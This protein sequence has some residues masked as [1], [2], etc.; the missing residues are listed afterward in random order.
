M[1]APPRITL[2]A[3]EDRT[4]REL[5]EARSVPQRT[6]D[7]AHRLRLNALGWNVPKIAKVFDFHQHTV[8][9]TLRRWEP[10]G[11]G[12]LWQA[13]GRGA[14]PRWKEEDLSG[15]RIQKMLKK[16]GYRWKR[17][18]KSQKRKQDPLGIAIKQADLQMLVRQAEEGVIELKYL[19]EA[20]FC[21]ESPP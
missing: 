15:D 18:R 14:K 2:T 11:L 1:P 4:L 10:R 8:R 5:R 17:T 16:K 20:G 3:E 6:R 9:A 19:D 21:L 7:R 13:P 12:G